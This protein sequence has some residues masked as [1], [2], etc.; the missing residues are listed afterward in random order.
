VPRDKPLQTVPTRRIEV[1]QQ[2]PRVTEKA[3]S[4]VLETP[5][6]EKTVPREGVTEQPDKK[7][8]K[9]DAR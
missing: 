6:R 8:R 2:T 1:P 4:R 7:D 9:N 5:V 3:P